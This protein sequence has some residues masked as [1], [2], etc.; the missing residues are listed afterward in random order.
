MGKLVT[1]SIQDEVI[2]IAGCPGELN[3]VTNK[4]E[5]F[6][7]RPDGQN[8]EQK[9]YSDKDWANKAKQD[10]NQPNNLKSIL[11]TERFILAFYYKPVTVKI[12]GGKSAK[13]QL[14]LGQTLISQYKH[15]LQSGQAK[16]QNVFNWMTSP[17]IYSN[18]E[19]VVISKGLL[20][21]IDSHGEDIIQFLQKNLADSIKFGMTSGAQDE[22]SGNFSR[23]KDVVICDDIQ[24][25]RSAIKSSNIIENLNNAVIEY[26]QLYHNQDCDSIEFVTRPEYYKFDKEYLTDYARQLRREQSNKPTELETMFSKLKEDV[27]P[28]TAPIMQRIAIREVLNNN[29]G[30]YQYT[31]L[32]NQLLNSMSSKGRVEYKD[33]V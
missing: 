1:I 16:L 30:V 7:T 24:D 26:K 11:I 22:N 8:L 15:Q 17:R 2:K 28:D 18:I 25:I 33:Y 10:Y 9:I 32:K 13:K 19:E 23:L 14:N 12:H 4:Y 20:R 21:Y 27:G 6:Y 31:N 3:K 29:Q 5:P